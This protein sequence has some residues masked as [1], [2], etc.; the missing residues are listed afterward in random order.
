METERHP[1]AESATGTTRPIEFLSDVLTQ[2]VLT[3]KVPT[4]VPTEEHPSPNLEFS[5]AT[6][7]IALTN[8]QSL[9]AEKF[10]ALA[11][12][13]SHLRHQREMRSLQVT[14]SSVG[15]GKT[16]IAGNLAATI[17]V[18]SGSKVLLVDGDLHRSALAV[19]FGV[20][21]SRGL[22]HWWSRQDADLAEYLYKMRD[23]P[24]WFLG[25]G[26]V[27]DEPSQILQSA[28]F[29]EAFSRL[30]EG[31]DWVVVDSAP[32]S[33]TVSTNLWARLLDGTLLVVREG[34]TSVKDLKNG[35]EA[36]DSPKLVGMVLNEAS[37]LGRTSYSI[38]PDEQKGRRPARNGKRLFD[39]VLSRRFRTAPKRVFRN[40]ADHPSGDEQHDHRAH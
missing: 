30:A 17:A 35:L 33:P 1:R 21:E 31:F 19:L 7:L 4:E 22:S 16:L 24:L 9:A 40:G 20:G 3:Q 18:Q 14:S 5:P 28:R 13:L 2:D 12:R 27:S 26:R 25:A 38:Y 11:T 37:E 15:E 39:T 23:L 10:R 8:S 32:M 36:L 34:I 29:V 6:P